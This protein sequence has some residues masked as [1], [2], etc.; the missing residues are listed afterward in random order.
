MISRS[1]VFRSVQ[2]C[3]LMKAPHS[4]FDEVGAC[5]FLLPGALINGFQQFLGQGNEHLGFHSIEPYRSPTKPVH[6]PLFRL[7]RHIPEI[8][9]IAGGRAGQGSHGQ[10]LGQSEPTRQQSSP[11]LRQP[12]GRWVRPPCSPATQAPP[13]Q[14]T[15][16]RRSSK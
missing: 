11:R 5:L 10:A 16:P 8:T 14:T 9:H 7:P 3:R 13:P 12:R 2:V 4:G 1:R 6:L 15:D